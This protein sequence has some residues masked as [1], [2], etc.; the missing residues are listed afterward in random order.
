ME[1]KTKTIDTS[2]QG[3]REYDPLATLGYPSSKGEYTR[4][5]TDSENK[6]FGLR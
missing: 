3:I 1:Q 2:H 4:N 5:K 6:W